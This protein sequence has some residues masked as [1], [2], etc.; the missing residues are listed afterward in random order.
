LVLW[1]LLAIGLPLLAEGLHR[2]ADTLEA[3]HGT[4]PT[5]RGLRLA[6]HAADNVRRFGRR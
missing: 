3:R 4:T 1:V 6:G 2:A 5:A